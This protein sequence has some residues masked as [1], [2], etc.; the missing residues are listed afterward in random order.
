DP[1]AAERQFQHV[2]GVLTR[3][4]ESEGWAVLPDGPAVAKAEPTLA[5]LV[6]PPRPP[7][8]VPALTEEV[9]ATHFRGIYERD[10][11]IRIIHD[12]ALAYA[13][14]LRAAQSEPS[15]EIARS[16]VLLKGRPAAAKTMLFER[17]KALYERHHR[18]VYGRDDEVVS[19]LDLHTATKAG[20]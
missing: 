10:H 1:A 6:R 12:S 16:H 9:L 20:V 5:D 3:C 2:L 19:F 7:F 13:A 14:S 4:A 18:D 8:V 17:F 15:V 11:H